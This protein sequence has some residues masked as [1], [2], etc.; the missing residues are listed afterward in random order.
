MDSLTLL[1]HLSFRNPKMD[2]S[3][4]FGSLMTVVL[5][6]EKAHMT[7]IFTC[8][9]SNRPVRISDRFAFVLSFFL[10]LLVMYYGTF[11]QNT[12]HKYKWSRKRKATRSEAYHGSPPNVT[13]LHKTSNHLALWGTQGT[14]TPFGLHDCQTGRFFPFCFVQTSTFT[15]ML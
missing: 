9:T 10:I 2:V 8:G 7:K 13:F 1:F 12:Y 6:V 14:K 11:S 3:L 5:F 4:F 15:Q